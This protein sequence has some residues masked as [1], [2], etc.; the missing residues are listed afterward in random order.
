MSGHF[1]DLFM[2]FY[3]IMQSTCWKFITVL[4]FFSVERIGTVC[5]FRLSYGRVL[6]KKSKI[7]AVNRNKSQLF[8][9]N[10]KMVLFV[11]MLV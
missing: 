7:I 8:K 1:Y 6:N 2:I 9:V 3:Q 10:Y 4:P 5:D 11:N